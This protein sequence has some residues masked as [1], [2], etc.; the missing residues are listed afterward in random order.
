VWRPLFGFSVG[1][2]AWGGWLGGVPDCGC[3]QSQFAKD[4]RQSRAEQK[5]R[6]GRD[7]VHNHGQLASFYLIVSLW[8]FL[9]SLPSLH[10]LYIPLLAPLG[11]FIS[12][13]GRGAFDS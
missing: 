8:V 5:A 9:L 2:P 3:M 6:G 13:P 11:L 4:G 10:P 12:C 1:H 7:V